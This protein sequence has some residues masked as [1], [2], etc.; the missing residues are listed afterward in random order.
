[1]SYNNSMYQLARLIAISLGIC[2]LCI[3][4]AH[5]QTSG[6]GD[7]F[8]ISAPS[9]FPGPNET[10]TLEAVSTSADLSV[11][12]IRWTVNGIVRQTGAG[13]TTLTVT[14]GALGERTVIGVSATIPGQPPLQ[15]TLTIVP[16]A[17]SIVWETDTS[18]PP[19]YHGKPLLSSESPLTLMA[20]P[21]I[22]SGGT[23]V[24]PA[25]LIYTWKKNG[26]TLPQSG[27]GRRSIILPGP[28]RFTGYSI[29]VVAATQDGSLAARTTIFMNARDPEAIIYE[30]HPL[31]GTRFNQPLT[32]DMT[33]SDDEATL[34]VE[35][36]Y[37]SRSAISSD[38]TTTW[39]INRKPATTPPSEGREITLRRTDASGRS[40]IGVFLANRANDLQDATASFTLRFGNGD[41]QD[42]GSA[43]PFGNF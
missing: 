30:Q 32:G 13:A 22:I 36:F 12:T 11:S 20:L 28:Q 27:M 6:S 38:L 29:E 14:S 24:D 4:S 23:P 18:V 39:S 37:F 3:S 42:A 21:A 10:I 5:A 41:E 34:R 33:L 19:W 25:K 26:F 15:T 31:L 9:R 16:A 7:D 17:V 43:T 8:S 2:A 35:P 1:M 40:S